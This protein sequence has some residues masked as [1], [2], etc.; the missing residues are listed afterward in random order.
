MQ[1]SPPGSSAAP[2]ALGTRES[3][4]TRRAEGK[5]RPNARHLE[6]GLQLQH[7]AAGGGSGK[8]DGQRVWCSLQHCRQ[9]LDLLWQ[10]MQSEAKRYA[11]Q[12]GTEVPLIQH[13][14]VRFLEF[15]LNRVK[16]ITDAYE[17]HSWK[18]K[19]RT[20]ETSRMR[21]TED[22]SRS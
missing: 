20:W 5:G 14:L 2:G 17:L 15:L 10:M 1:W 9:A 12:N 19:P 4:Q 22:E 8:L 21:K 18:D 6:P 16:R 13:S 11:A 7:A 3:V